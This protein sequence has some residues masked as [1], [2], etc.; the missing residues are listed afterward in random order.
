MGKLRGPSRKALRTPGARGPQ[1]KNCWPNG[2]GHGFV[3]ACSSAIEDPPSRGTQKASCRSLERG[4]QLRCRPCRLTMSAVVGLKELHVYTRLGRIKAGVPVTAQ[5]QVAM[6]FMHDGAPAH[7]STA[8]RNYLRATYPGS[9]IRRGGPIACSTCS[10]DLDFLNFFFWGHLKTAGRRSLVVKVTNS[11]PACRKFEPST[12]EDPPCREARHVKS[13]ESSNVLPLVLLTTLVQKSRAVNQET[14]TCLNISRQ[15]VSKLWK[16][17]Q[18]DGT[19]VRRP[20]QGQKRMTT[21]SEDRYLALTARRNRKATARQ[22]S[23]KLAA[24]TGAVASR[25][26]IYRRLNEKAFMPESQGYVFYCL[27][28]KEGSRFNWCKEHQNWTKHQ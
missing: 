1:F 15:T 27:H 11:W 19:V 14:A 23:S 26:T 25:Q 9:W 4:C 6:C 22:L 20:G 21:A 5:H 17:F 2:Y 3:L 18:N 10:T 12:T 8:V 24:A 28:R 13:V 16:Q 7:F